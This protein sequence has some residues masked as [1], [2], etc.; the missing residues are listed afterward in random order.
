MGDVSRVRFNG[1]VRS[2]RA[3]LAIAACL[4]VA[5]MPVRRVG[6]TPISLRALSR[7][8]AAVLVLVYP[9]TSW[10]RPVSRRGP[11]YSYLPRPCP[12]ERWRHRLTWVHSWVD[13]VDSDGELLARLSPGSWT[14]LRRP[15]GW[16]RLF[17]VPSDLNGD[18]PPALHRVGI[19]DLEL[20]RG[21]YHYVAVVAHDPPQCLA[22][23][24]LVPSLDL[25]RVPVRGHLFHL[26]RD[27][28][29]T[30][31]AHPPAPSG[32]RFPDIATLRRRGAARL[33][34]SCSAP[35]EPSGGP[36]GRV[37]PIPL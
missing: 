29:R 17:V 3:A 13:V 33:R 16:H 6:T 14:A 8:D 21:F 31:E 12:P 37:V 23:P 28:L 15:P 35:R 36:S 27:A 4:L 7:E 20:A 9:Q 22:G 11:C 5:C 18:A 30:G 2:I 10:H 26:V 1:E 32:V 19:M 25:E 34:D 24:P